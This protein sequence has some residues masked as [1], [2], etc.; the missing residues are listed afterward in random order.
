MS[1]LAHA[2]LG[3]DIAPLT[4]M[5]LLTGWTFQPL[6][7]VIVI[8][9]ASAYLYGVH[10]LRRRGDAWSRWRSASFVGLGLGSM[11]VATQ[12]A[13]STYDTSLLSVHMAQHMVLSML[14]PLFLA[15]G[16]PVT[17]ALRTLPGRPRAVLM[18]IL[19]SRVARV[20]SFPPLTFA[21]FI[22]TPWALYFTGWYDATLHNPFLHDL[23]HLQFITVGCLFF[24]PLVGLDPVP[25]RLPYMLRVLVV[26]ATLPFHAFL[27]VTVMAMREL[28]GGDW[29]RE[30]DRHWGPSP[31]YD[32]QIAGSILWAA[33][34][35]IGAVLFGVLFVQWVRESQREAVREDRRLDRLEAMANRRADDG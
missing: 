35:L 9:L 4:P 15:L 28:I 5:R 20:L 34:D 10:R 33:G 19:H 13:L 29:Y 25:G 6:M 17:L 2:G 24:W 27:G 16:A 3:D 12:S 1:I 23:L 8:A 11:T 26:F 21:M 18:A 32:Q 14:V 7:A 30:L 22:V 31:L